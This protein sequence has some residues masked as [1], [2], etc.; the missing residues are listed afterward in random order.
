[1]SRRLLAAVAVA[2]TCAAAQVDTNALSLRGSR[3]EGS[4][5]LPSARL[6]ERGAWEISVGYGHD[7]EVVRVQER[8]GD[9]RGGALTQQTKW[10]DARNLAWVHLAVSPLSRF[11]LNAS[12]PVLLT[13]TS[14]PLASTAAPLAGTPALGDVALGLRFALLEPKRFGEQGLQWSL[15]GNVIAPTGNE[16][17]A[18]SESVTRV[19][20]STTLTWQSGA[21][22]AV[23]AHAGWQLGRQLQLDD[24][25]FGQ[26]LVFGGAFAYRIS[27]FQLHADVLSNV[28]LGDAAVQTEPGRASLELL[29]G[30][31]WVHEYFF[32][33]LAAG[34]APVDDGPTPRWRLQLAIGAR[35]LFD[36]PAPPPV[37]LDPD[38]DGIEGDADQCPTRAEDFDGFQDDDGCPDLDDDGDGIPDARDACPRDPE[39][40]D[41]IADADG[42]PET[43][44]DADGIPDEQ[45][46][47]P[48]AP[49]DFD[50]FE[51]DDGCPEAGSVDPASTFR[52]LSL[53]EQVVFFDVGSAKL[54]ANATA[55][56]R[57]IAR[58]LLKRD[59]ALVLTGHADD[60]GAEARNDELSLQR[61]EAVKAVLVEA[62]V[63]AARLTTRG[64]G[65]RE[66]VTKAAGF[67]HSINR[68]VTFT[69]A[70]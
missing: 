41:G 61:A 26:R 57:E 33:D 19:D 55:S 49:E 3:V 16:A 28:A 70:K 18:F 7:G 42:C 30:V 62:G 48:L 56:L 40:K 20:A 46:K 27:D 53:A 8:T 59:G 38:R 21:A 1:M 15:Q 44:A 4:A 13:Q 10:L 11:E 67:G 39:D 17:A 5:V 66:P 51:D 34:G 9:V 64:A 47:C 6:L 68:A 12:L 36:K 43:D 22:W 63:P 58:A 54:D 25:L 37:D 32:A 50:G 52:A 2:S 14:N 31:R 65:R 29:G 24:Q 35:G 23:T 45:D 60:Q 69:W